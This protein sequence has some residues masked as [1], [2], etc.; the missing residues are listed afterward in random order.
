MET[1]QEVLQAVES[2]YNRL[3]KR[4]IMLYIVNYV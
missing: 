2:A 1:P 4:R 3:V